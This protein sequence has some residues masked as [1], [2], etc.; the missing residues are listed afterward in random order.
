MNTKLRAVVCG[1]GN[2][3][4][5][6]VFSMTSLGFHVIALDR[7]PK[8]AMNLP[9]GLFDFFTTEDHDSIRKVIKLTNPHV[10][11]SS[12]PYH[13]TKDLAD[14]CLFSGY[15]YCDLGGRVD[16]SK[17]IN[18]KSLAYKGK[19]NAHCFTDLG[20]APGWVNIL[21]EHGIKQLHGHAHEIE[22]IKMMVGGLP[23]EPNNP[24]LNYVANWSL[25]GLLN[26]YKDDCKIL[27]DGR[28]VVV[29]GMDGVETVM[30]KSAGELE[31]FYTS[32]G[33]SHTIDSMAALGVKDC[34]YK[35]L[36]YKGHNE[37]MKFLIRDCELDESCILKI[38]E[39][40][41]PT[42]KNFEDMVV[43]KVMI[44][45][46]DNFWEK[47]LLIPHS[48]NFSAMQKATA[49]S[50]SSVAKMMAEDFFNENA[51]QHRDY[52]DIPPIA[53]TYKLVDYEEF[54][55]N[56]NILRGHDSIMDVPYEPDISSEM[57]APPEKT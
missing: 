56:I 3:G 27:K 29:R 44:K 4:K 11:I 51:A 8:S 47:E 50:I 19:H 26:E 54:M 46:K 31:A 14:F 10:V 24:P 37:L 30:T 39:K 6:I 13:Q 18:R 43:I 2:M 22:F 1:V 32:G 16:V 52:F 53:L 48:H 41:K 23:K 49:F 45:A 21:A 57:A 25:D 42:N 9:D 33:S 12:L 7:D 34:S 40:A 15:N 55:K 20:L 38:F 28:E 5:A 36:R 35:T 17:Y